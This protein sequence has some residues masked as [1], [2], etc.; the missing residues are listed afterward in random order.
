M[1]KILVFVTMIMVALSGTCFAQTK[2]QIKDAKKQA[3]LLQKEGWKS[4]SHRT[5]ESLLLEFTM[6]EE[7]NEIYVGRAEDYDNEKVAKNAARRDALRECVEVANSHFKGIGDELEGKLK[8]ET[9][10]NLTMAATSKFEG[11]VTAGFNVKFTIYKENKNGKISCQSFCF[12]NKK[13]FAEAEKTAI[14]EAAEE[15]GLEAKAVGDYSKE[16]TNI[17]NSHEF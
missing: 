2:S 10:D 15:A 3:K 6:L 16:V 13:K 4:D 9:I 11:K 17:I 8:T 12:I 7:E 14:Q 5:L 1:K